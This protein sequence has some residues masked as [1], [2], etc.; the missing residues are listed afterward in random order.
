MASQTSTSS[1]AQLSV[2][3]ESGIEMLSENFLE[4]SAQA[5]MKLIAEEEAELA[6][7]EGEQSEKKSGFIE[8]INDNDR[9]EIALDLLEQ[10]K[11]KQEPK[12]ALVSNTYANYDSNTGQQIDDYGVVHSGLESLVAE[13]DP[14]AQTQILAENKVEIKGDEKKEAKV[15]ATKTNGSNASATPVVMGPRD[16]TPH[17]KVTDIYTH[18]YDSITKNGWDY[19]SPWKAKNPY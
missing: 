19:T 5:E 7:D 10:E 14:E 6:L 8:I 1:M 11:P 3:A 4:S 2:D 18:A 15:A 13:R 12:T 16:Q 9:E 17:E